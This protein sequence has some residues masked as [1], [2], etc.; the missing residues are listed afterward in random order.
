MSGSCFGSSDAEENVD[1]AEESAETNATS[2]PC[3]EDVIMYFTPVSGG[4]WR[5][6]D[7]W[8]TSGVIK[9]VPQHLKVLVNG[10]KSCQG[11]R[12]FFTYLEGPRVKNGVNF[13]EG[14]VG[15]KGNVAKTSEGTSTLTTTNPHTA[16]CDITVTYSSHDIRVYSGSG[17]Q[18]YVV[19][20]VYGTFTFAGVT[21]DVRMQLDVIA[22]NQSWKLSIPDFP[23]PG[24]NN[25]RADL[26]TVWFR[27]DAPTSPVDWTGHGTGND[28]YFHLGRGSAGCFTNVS[29]SGSDAGYD[30]IA[31]ALMKCRDGTDLYV[32]QITFDIPSTTY[33]SI[34]AELVTEARRQS[35][36][37]VWNNAVHSP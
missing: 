14:L 13:R 17:G 12:F 36:S 15:R 10:P 6:R 33:A 26:A 1:E 23:H 5:A 8:S 30:T 20:S 28:R 16:A 29:D 32:G 2:V 9:S 19:A 4:W 21:K 35:K 25:Y 37:Y 27:V 34:E 11:D 22:P 24:G 18:E 3:T 31:E 7:T